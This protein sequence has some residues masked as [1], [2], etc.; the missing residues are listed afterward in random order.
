MNGEVIKNFLVGLQ[1]DVDKG[2][3]SK[4]SAALEQSGFK[5]LL[6]KAALVGAATALYKFTDKVAESL[7]SLQ[8]LSEQTG[9]A[10]NDISEL[11][12]VAEQSDSSLSAVESTMAGLS[13]TMGQ[14]A[15]GVG[16][17][18]M[19]FKKLGLSAKDA[20]GQI[21][22]TKDMLLEIGGRLRK[23]SLQEQLAMMSK[24][25]IDPSLRKTLTTDITEKLG[26]YKRLQ[27]GL[28]LD[29]GQE[30]EI[31]STYVDAHLKASNLVSTIWRSAATKFIPHF[32]K[33]FN[34][35]SR[36]IMA[37]LPQIKR[38]IEIITIPI[39]A[40]ID[41]FV[42]IAEFV[43]ATLDT[44]DS[45]TGGWTS[46]ILA[47]VA[48]IWLLNTAWL[49]TP[50]GRLIALGAALKLIYDDYVGFTEGKVAAFDW[51]KILGWITSVKVGFYGLGSMIKSVFQGLMDYVDALVK[52]SNMDFSGAAS[53]F[54]AGTS[55]F[56]NMVPDAAAAGM[57][58]VTI[59]NITTIDVAATDP[60]AAGD[61]VIK[62]QRGVNEH[63]GAV[64][65]GA[66]KAA[67]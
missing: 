55:K 67:S 58:A 23:L 53:S 28:G 41:G 34:A 36:L 24:L 65:R 9:I 37:H 48:A 17:G 16:R 38:A 27:D 52:F 49:N 43:G 35:F 2:G 3:L 39:N 25:G 1:F 12:Y 19:T 5:A 7:D 13:N 10:V 47:L 30:A 46:S 64:T 4:F 66:L 20:K 60:K 50:I 62:G 29:V 44:L 18:A 45:L 15:L 61:A 51:E 14:A 33:A 32:T 42:Q 56:T 54:A 63:S 31:A 11:G 57:G 21:K 26:E 8:D 40:I 6:Q 22:S 59:N